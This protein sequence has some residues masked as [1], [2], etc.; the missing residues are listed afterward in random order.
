MNNAYASPASTIGKVSEE[1]TLSRIH[2][3]LVDCRKRLSDISGK[4]DSI[5]NGLFGGGLA[6]GCANECVPARGGIIGSI[7]DVIDGICSEISEMESAV[8]RIASAVPH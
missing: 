5:G 3:R 8:S 2:G 6:D 7:E 1:P 4:A